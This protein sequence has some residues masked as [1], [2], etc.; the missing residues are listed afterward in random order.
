[1]KPPILNHVA[2]TVARRL[3]SDTPERRH[4]LEFYE[5]VFGWRAID[6]MSIEGQR[7]V[8]HLHQVTHF[9]YLVGGDVPTAAQAGDHFG[10]E[11]YEAET[12]AAI[13]DRAKAFKAERDPAVEVVD[14]TTEDYGPIR[15]H[16][17]YVRYLLPLMVEVQ[18]YEGV[19]VRLDEI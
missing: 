17:A 3:V 10:I 2:L 11:V 4:L 9:L 7:V 1:M 12:L 14:I 16:N 6:V 15:I 8:L 5:R 13:V 18:Y 19:E